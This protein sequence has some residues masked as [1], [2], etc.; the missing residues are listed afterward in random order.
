[1]DWVRDLNGM[2]GMNVNY[3]NGKLTCFSIIYT[4]LLWIIFNN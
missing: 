3:L 1:M 2:I 4:F